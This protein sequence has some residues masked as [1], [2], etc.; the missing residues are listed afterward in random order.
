[1]LISSVKR[2]GMEILLKL[3]GKSLIY[4]KKSKDPRIYP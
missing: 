3:L 1:M 4:I 2:T